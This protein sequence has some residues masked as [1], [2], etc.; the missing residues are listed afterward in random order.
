MI[1]NFGEGVPRVRDWQAR[2]GALWSA[3]SGAI[4]SHRSRRC[5]ARGLNGNVVRGLPPKSMAVPATVS[6]ERDARAFHLRAEGSHWEYRSRE[7]AHQAV[8][9][10]PGDLPAWV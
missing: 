1:S 8:T 10:E 4:R 5:P 7:G 2:P 6:G 9:R 3:S